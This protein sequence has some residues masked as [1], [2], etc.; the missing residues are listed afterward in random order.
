MNDRTDGYA[1]GLEYLYD[2]QPEVGPLRVQLALLIAGIAPPRITTACELG[3]GQGMSVNIH[4]A[5]QA[6]RWFGTD[7][8]PTHV[9]FARELAAA[10]GADAQLDD[11]SF[12][13]FCARPDLPEFDL[14]A[15]HGV[16]SWVSEENRALIVDFLRRKLAVGGVVYISYNVQPGFSA[17]TPL[18]PVLMGHAAALGQTGEGPASRVD[19]A[20]AFAERVLAVSPGYAAAHPRLPDLLRSIRRE[21][22][23]YLAH[24]YLNANWAPT[25]FLRVTEALAAAK[26]EYACSPS[27]QQTPG[28]LELAAEQRKLL[29]EIRETSY[30]EVVR[31]L[32][33]NRSFRVDYWVKGPRRLASLERIE[34]LFEQRVMLIR[35]PAEVLSSF[36]NALATAVALHPVIAAL[37]ETLEDH[38][39]RSLADIQNLVAPRGVSVP[40]L[41][42]AIGALASLGAVTP[43]QIDTAAQEA[44]AR[45]GKLN[46][47]LCA[48]AIRGADVRALASPVTG[49][50]FAEVGGRIALFFVDG[51][52][53]GLRDPRDLAAQ[54]LQIFR[55]LGI[56]LFRDGRPVESAEDS[57]ALLTG[58]AQYF[59][60]RQLPALRAMQIIA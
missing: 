7:F 45:T 11:Q 44:R 28:S 8:N 40:Q 30:R 42:E 51:V 58:Q 56:G 32:M 18:H 10:S 39:P 13:E 43:V 54:A 60:D 48:K 57:L 3:F 22:R 9:G 16:W 33:A 27:L 59:L 38:R 21:D 35:Q 52:A 1:S 24:E 17:L 26:L 4:A 34:R 31:D 41:C 36:A 20:L 12:A 49:T 29:G 47:L 5:A 37:I 19:A 23:R 25:S 14:I 50:G 2:F 15:L 55:T 46:A 6:V 53:R